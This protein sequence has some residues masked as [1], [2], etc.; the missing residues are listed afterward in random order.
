[1]V[2]DADRV[3]TALRSQPR[4]DLLVPKAGVGADQNL[5]RGA[6]ATDAGEQFV[7]EPQRAALRVGLALSE[8][9]VQD[10]VAVGAGGQQRVV[11]EPV[12]VAVA[13]AL[14]AGA[15]DLT[16]ERVDIDH[17]P[18]IAW[19]GPRAPRAAQRLSEH[20]VELAHVPERE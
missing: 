11:A 18:L 3:A 12:R 13:G 5:P 17:Q 9:D 14:L 20:A 16:D 2:G 1:M 6:G 19:T 8:P 4:D 7:D 10:L 15:V